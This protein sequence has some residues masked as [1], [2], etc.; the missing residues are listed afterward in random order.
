MLVVPTSAITSL[1]LRCPSSSLSIALNSVR[2]DA[3]SLSFIG[4]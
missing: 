2:S 1:R 3:M 4:T